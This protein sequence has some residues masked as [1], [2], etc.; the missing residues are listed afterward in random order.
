MVANDRTLD[1]VDT[2]LV[3]INELFGKPDYQA[4][5]VDVRSKLLKYVDVL[6]RTLPTIQSERKML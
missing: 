5:F 3:D 6:Q 2:Q 4:R 1:Q